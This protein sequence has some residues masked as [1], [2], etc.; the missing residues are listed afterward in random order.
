M[1]KKVDFSKW[2]TP[3][4]LIK[5]NNGY[6]IEGY[7]YN[8]TTSTHGRSKG[9]VYCPCC[10]QGNDIFIWSFIGSGKRCENCKVL[11]TYGGAF[12]TK[13]EINKNIEQ[14]QKMMI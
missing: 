9:Y 3:I 8:K 10:K 13:E 1:A 14:W 4:K 11:I 2:K 7:G 12:V 6:K 5:T